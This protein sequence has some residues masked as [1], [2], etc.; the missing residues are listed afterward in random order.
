MGAVDCERQKLNVFRMKMLGA[1]A[2]GR[3]SCSR[4]LM[5]SST[6]VV[7]SWRLCCA[8]KLFQ[9]PAEPPSSCLLWFG[10]EQHVP[11]ARQK[12]WIDGPHHCTVESAIIRLC[13]GIRGSDDPPATPARS[14]RSASAPRIAA[15]KLRSCSSQNASRRGNRTHKQHDRCR[16]AFAIH[17][18]FLQ[19]V[20]DVGALS[21]RTSWRPRSMRAP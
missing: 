12:S 8:H 7:V 10:F 5:A 17:L 19:R 3:A 21:S 6:R 15:A 20:R 18:A 11:P 16:H 13:S 1:K 4:R 14:S 9:G 2:S